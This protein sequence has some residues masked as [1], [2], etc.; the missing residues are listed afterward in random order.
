MVING[1]V[2]TEARQARVALFQKQKGFDVMLLSP[3]AGGV[4]LTLTA[5]N[6]VIHLSR[7]WNPAVEDQ[8]SDRVYR[9]GQEKPVHIYYPLAV[10]PEVENAS[11]DE[12]LQILMDRKRAR[13]R[14]LL[15]APAFTPEDYGDLLRG[16][17]IAG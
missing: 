10:L 9:I 7:W 1:E 6:H 8:C 4:G 3:K 5:A 14:D 15:E 16:T 13:A 12:Q 2:S 17:G 11:F